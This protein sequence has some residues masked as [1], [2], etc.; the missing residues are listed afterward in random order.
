MDMAGNQVDLSVGAARTDR[1]TRK[2]PWQIWVVITFLAV[3]GL[4]GNLPMIPAYPPAAIWFGAK[5]LFIVGL[6]KGWRWVFVLFLV[7]G[8]IHVLALSTQAPFVAFLNLVLVILTASA[9]RF[10]FPR[11][12]SV[13]IEQ[14]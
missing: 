2:S 3:E 8:A 9:L 14:P 5:C 7:I 10:Y 12:A 11:M 4:L 13:G 1:S 6:L